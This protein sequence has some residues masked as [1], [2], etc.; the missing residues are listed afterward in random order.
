MQK[1][2]DENKQTGL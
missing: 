2:E 1:R